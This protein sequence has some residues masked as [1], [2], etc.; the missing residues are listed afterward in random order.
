[1]KM[2]EFKAMNYHIL[3]LKNR[4]MQPVK[5]HRFFS[6]KSTAVIW[7]QSAT[8]SLITIIFEKKTKS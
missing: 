2:K 8:N 7:G 1:M 5:I 4:V 3:L 6:F